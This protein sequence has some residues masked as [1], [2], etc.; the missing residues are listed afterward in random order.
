MQPIMDIQIEIDR[1]EA[2][3]VKRLESLGQ[4]ELSSLY[5][6]IITLRKANA[7]LTRGVATVARPRQAA[8]TPAKKGNSD[9]EFNLRN[10]V[11]EQIIAFG[12]A[13]FTTRQMF[14]ALAEKYPT[15]VTKKRLPSV[16]ATMANLF[17]KNEVSKA[18]D[19]EGKLIFRATE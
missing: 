15:D 5:T 17:A 3:F 14:E 12:G 18:M 9:T 4:Q 6:D 11:R 19:D 16:S 10:A 7:V 1:R 8:N 2:D 13:P